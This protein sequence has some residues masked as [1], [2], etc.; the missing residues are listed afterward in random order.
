[1]SQIKAEVMSASFSP[2]FIIFLPLPDPTLM[3]TWVDL[4]GVE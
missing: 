4:G 1:M 3:M 2:S